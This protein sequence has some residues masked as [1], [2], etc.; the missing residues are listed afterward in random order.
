MSAK[1]QDDSDGDSLEDVN[2]FDLL[3][4]MG[5]HASD[6]EDDEE[7]EDEWDIEVFRANIWL[8]VLCVGNWGGRLSGYAWDGSREDDREGDELSL[9]EHVH[10]VMDSMRAERARCAMP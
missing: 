8:D 10:L 5:W 9:V 3:D 4:E 7:E 6:E 2:P 1:I